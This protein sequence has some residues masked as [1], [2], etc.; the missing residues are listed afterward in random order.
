MACVAV[1][2]AAGDAPFSFTRKEFAMDGME[3][4][5]FALGFIAS[6]CTILMFAEDRFR[7]FRLKLRRK[8]MRSGKQE[9][10][11]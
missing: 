6:I 8:K 4:V 11:E 2:A 9:A 10:R 3:A 5:A 7:K 1:F